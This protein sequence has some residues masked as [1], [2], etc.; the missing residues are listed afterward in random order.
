M[1]KITGPMIEDS[2]YKM[3]TESEL[4]KTG[5]FEFDQKAGGLHKG[6]V[7]LLAGCS[8]IG[9]TSFVLN[10]VEH[11]GIYGDKKVAF[12]SGKEK[13]EQIVTSL[14]KLVSRSTD[15][16]AD[17]TKTNAAINDIINAGIY[18]KEVCGQKIQAITHDFPEDADLLILDG[19]EELDER[20]YVSLALLKGYAAQYNCAIIVTSRANNDKYFHVNQKI[21]QRLA[22]IMYLYREEFFHPNSQ[23]KNIANLYVDKSSDNKQFAVSLTWQ[24][25]YR[26]FSSMKKDNLL[27]EKLLEDIDAQK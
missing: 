24:P 22:N 20:E 26:Q 17:E 15:L 10:L 5:Y 3:R 27:F 1:E 7:Y 25:E 9:K 6:E 8:G 12:F 23:L 11:I 21:E 16:L 2:I 4:I 13:K 19:L 14:V 18:L